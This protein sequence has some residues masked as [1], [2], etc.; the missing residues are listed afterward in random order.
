MPINDKHIEIVIRCSARSASRTRATRPSCH[1]VMDKF[2][3]RRPAP[4]ADMVRVSGGRPTWP[5]AGA[6]HESQANAKAEAGRQPPARPS[7]RPERCCWHHKASLQSDSFL[8]GRHSGDDRSSPRRRLKGA[9]DTLVNSGRALGRWSTAATTATSSG[10]SLAGPSTGATGRAMLERPRCAPGTRRQRG[11]D[12]A[13]CP[14]RSAR[15][16]ARPTPPAPDAAQ[17]L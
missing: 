14:S 15:A 1:D 6:Q 13:R 17:S 3:F 11:T 2:V 9:V 12:T 4:D 16:S 10:L 7:P 5:S 8:S